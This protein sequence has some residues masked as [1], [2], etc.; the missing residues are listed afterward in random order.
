MSSKAKYKCDHE[1]NRH[2]VCAVCGKKIVFGS[3]ASS[4]FIINSHLESLIKRF[5][6]NGFNLLDSRFPK[7]ICV[8]CK[9]AIN[10]RN[11]G[12][13][14]RFLPQMPNFDDIQLLKETRNRDDLE[15]NCYICQ[16]GRQK[17]H[18]H[19]GKFVKGENL[20][21]TTDNG[22]I[23]AKKTSD[24]I[25][26][27][28][29]EVSVQV[30]P[31]I[32]VCKVCLS[33]IAKGKSHICNVN[34]AHKNVVASINNLPDKSKDKL[35]HELLANKAKITEPS[36]SL[37][38][39]EISLKTGGRDSRVILN[40]KST[41]PIVFSEEKLDNFIENSGGFFLENNKFVFVNL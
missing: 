16:V 12:K 7:A 21:I 17:G 36:S 11:Q 25:M 1:E 28:P 35:L 33:E 39:V 40:P 14:E 30:E 32:K 10:Q 18:K 22:L 3:N 19:T 38:N 9:I 15:C 29:D 20:L 5:S 8:S 26:N 41:D 31:V 6:Y 24:A 23:A 4:K 13:I 34:L 37:R 27:K 2:K